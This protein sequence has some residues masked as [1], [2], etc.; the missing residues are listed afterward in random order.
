MTSEPV[1]DI[2]EDG[3]TI[4]SWD[5]CGP[6]PSNVSK[7]GLDAALRLDFQQCIIEK[8]NGNKK[9]EWIEKALQ[10]DAISIFLLPFVVR[11]G[12]PFPHDIMKELRLPANRSKQISHQEACEICSLLSA[13]DFHPQDIKVPS[14]MVWTIVYAGCYEMWQTRDQYMPTYN[15]LVM[16]SQKERP[17][18]SGG[19]LII[20]G[21]GRHSGAGVSNIDQLSPIA[22]LTQSQLT[23]FVRLVSTVRKVHGSVYLCPR[24]F[25]PDVEPVL[26]HLTTD[27]G[28]DLSKMIETAARPLI[29]LLRE[30]PMRFKSQEH[31]NIVAFKLK[32][33]GKKEFEFIYSTSS[34]PTCPINHQF[35]QTGLLTLR[36]LQKFHNLGFMVTLSE[37]MGESFVQTF[38]ARR[39][40]Q[41]GDGY[42][43][44]PFL[45]FGGQFYDRTLF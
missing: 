5:I 4:T 11:S 25:R 12:I 9:I 16:R 22:G 36:V 34:D 7:L 40:K 20:G 39:F 35:D 2:T 18:R 38:T 32:F 27:E 29:P 30:V 44:T 31:P 13:T 8:V 23:L 43:A 10:K 6:V 21:L 15:N 19:H 14:Y 42:R 17:L 28:T 41:D 1:F 3:P 37:V 45:T 24:D 33:Y 26:Q